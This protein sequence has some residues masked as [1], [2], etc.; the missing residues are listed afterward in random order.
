MQVSGSGVWKLRD[1]DT[2]AISTKIYQMCFVSEASSV[3]EGLARVGVRD[4]GCLGLS[5]GQGRALWASCL[6]GNPGAQPWCQPGWAFVSSAGD[7][8]WAA[9]QGRVCEGN[10][11]LPP[12]TSPFPFVSKAEPQVLSWNEPRSPERSPH[13][14]TR[15][16]GTAPSWADLNECPLKQQHLRK[17]V[18]PPL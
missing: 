6:P 12:H 9:P 10:H 11:H 3:S 17:K 15:K 5:L 8:S 1:G 13:T 7:F 2:A 14:C 16:M 18:L 4:E